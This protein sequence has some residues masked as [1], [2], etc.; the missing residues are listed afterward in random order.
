MKLRRQG[1]KL[2]VTF[3]K[4]WTEGKKGL[5]IFGQPTSSKNLCQVGFYTL[6]STTSI[7]LTQLLPEN[8]SLWGESRVMTEK[9]NGILF[10]S[11]DKTEL[12]NFLENGCKWKVLGPGLWGGDL[13]GLGGQR[14][15]CDRKVEGGDTEG[16]RVQ[17]KML[18]RSKEMG[19]RAGWEQRIIQTKYVCK[20]YNKTCYSVY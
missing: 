9:K 17:A 4:S 11:E 6:Q 7:W 13:K 1:V 2:R 16:Q 18:Q 3:V 8:F 19:R 5:V 12:W 15:T 20:C 14:D 10:S